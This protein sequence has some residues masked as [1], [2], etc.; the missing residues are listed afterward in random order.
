MCPVTH[1][2]TINRSN[3]SFVLN[4]NTYTSAIQIMLPLLSEELK[5]YEKPKH[6]FQRKR[7]HASVIS[8]RPITNKVKPIRLKKNIELFFLFLFS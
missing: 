2:L 5:F 4:Y 8:A 6:N 3:L 7:N 1:L